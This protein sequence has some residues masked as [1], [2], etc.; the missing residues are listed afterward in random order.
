[1]VRR[2]G[3]CCVRLACVSISANPSSGRPEHD[4]VACIK[5]LLNVINLLV[6]Y[7]TKQAVCLISILVV[8]DIP[9][10]APANA[11]HVQSML[12]DNC[13]KLTMNCGATH[14]YSTL[15]M[16]W[17]KNSSRNRRKMKSSSMCS[18]PISSSPKASSYRILTVRPEIATSRIF[19][20]RY[21]LIYCWPVVWL[22]CAGAC[23][24]DKQDRN[25]LLL[26]RHE[27]ICCACR[28]FIYCMPLN[29]RAK[30]ETTT[31]TPP[32]RATTNKVSK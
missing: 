24:K 17:Q 2:D 16:S 25:E 15:L 19:D 13:S 5:T 21:M 4:S 9:C 27:S 3:V 18:P 14:Q 22:E 10:H 12:A 26:K 29:W 6:F 30:Q 8:R 7:S 28:K 32:P 20:R 31:T 11:N 23:M 1:M